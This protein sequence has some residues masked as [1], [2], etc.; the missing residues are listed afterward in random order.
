MSTTEVRGEIPL[1]EIQRTLSEALG[2]AYR[3]TATSDSTLKIRRMP[4]MTATVNVKRDGD[5]TTLQAA[6]GQAWILQ[7]INALTIY[8]KLRHTLTQALPSA[9]GRRAPSTPAGT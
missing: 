7:G 8:P 3:V 4:L 9:P 2:R 5:K 6:P 1:E